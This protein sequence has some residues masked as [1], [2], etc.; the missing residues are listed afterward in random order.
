MQQGVETKKPGPTSRLS[1]PQ[2]VL[3]ALLGAPFVLGLLAAA[4]IAIFGWNWAREPLQRQVLAHTGRVLLM[5]G[6]LKVSLGWPALRVQVNDLSFAN[7]SW[8]A[9]PQMLVLQAADFSVDLP[10]LWRR[11]VYL[12]ELR[13]NQPRLMLEAAPD[14]RRSWLLDQQQSDE[15]KKL[16][17][18]RL[19]LDQGQIGFVD[20]RLKTR[21]QMGL[22]TRNNSA[23]EVDFQAT[24]TFKDMPLLANGHGGS[25][26]ALRDV[27]TPYPIE[28]EATIGRTGMRAQGSIT[29]PVSM[30]AVNL[31][32]AVHGDSLA[33]LFPLLGVGLP[34]TRSYV[35]A[36]HLSH[37][38]K[39]WRFEK[40]SG[41]VG[42][43]D[44]AGDV[45]IELGG[46]RPKLS[47][48]L[49]SQV[50][51]FDDLGPLIGARTTPVA[52][53]A[54]STS[55]PAPRT[56]S[57]TPAPGPATAARRVLP[58]LPFHTERWS[59]FDADVTLHANSIRRTKAMQLDQLQAHVQM[60]DAVLTLAPL[61]LEAAGGRLSA[62]VRLDA[63]RGEIT[64]SAK[65]RLTKMTLAQLLP[66]LALPPKSLGRVS[67]DF[68]MVGR[69]NAVSR[70]LATADGHVRLVAERGEISHLMMERMGLHLLEI[71]KLNITGDKNI[72]LR[73]AVADFQAVRGVMTARS[74]LLDT[75]VSTVTGSG[76]IDLATEKL[77][78]TLMPHTRKTSIVALRSP[79]YLRGSFGAPTVALDTQR[80]IARGAGALALGLINPLLA[81]LPLVEMGPGV[82]ADC[83]R[84]VPPAPPAPPAPPKK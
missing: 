67:G 43:S 38:G 53:A 21:I 69:G 76:T 37:S 14:G 80:V 2:L 30:A 10:S 63:R 20:S 56:P 71:L 49:V 19:M 61:D 79:I 58:D 48:Q 34:E 5:A 39:T 7:P 3:L 35:V 27:N 78:L 62:D 51:D 54:D 59:Q 84:P 6:D 28:V 9:E 50:L 8:A 68:A 57:D 25:L 1:R 12:P 11:Q 23:A 24:G 18:G 64:S 33:Q 77:D 40:F 83:A 72:E 31:Q 46:V 73:C 75:D 47:G 65:G 42:R 26:L 60:Q 17:I 55:A 29:G 82:E 4:F 45:Q 32:V 36:G 13:L 22:N 70:M 15:R 44:L 74:L 66:D 41:R 81:L 16:L 52:S